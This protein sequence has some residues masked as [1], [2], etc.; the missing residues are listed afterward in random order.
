ML[1]INK[2]I[3]TATLVLETLYYFYYLKNFLEIILSHMQRYYKKSLLQLL[4]C[5]FYYICWN[6]LF[7]ECLQAQNT[8]ISER[9]NR[10]FGSCI[11]HLR[12]TLKLDDEDVKT[13]QTR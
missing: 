9:N 10:L 6:N 3:S 8:P 13:D 4:P 2:N 5:E 11:I 12:P 7:T 1:S